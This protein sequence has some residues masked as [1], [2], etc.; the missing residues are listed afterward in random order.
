MPS[1]LISG[2]DV[3]LR[4]SQAAEQLR[5][6]FGDCGDDYAELQDELQRHLEADVRP[7]PRNPLHDAPWSLLDAIPLRLIILEPLPHGAS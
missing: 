1:N 7:Q 6:A 4:G 2:V 5:V 3:G